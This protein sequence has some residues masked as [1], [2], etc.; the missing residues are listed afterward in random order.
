[1]NP[2][3]PLHQRR[4]GKIQEKKY[5][6]FQII[7]RLEERRKNGRIVSEEGPHKKICRFGSWKPDR[8]LTCVERSDASVKDPGILLLLFIKL[9]VVMK[10]ELMV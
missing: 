5:Q 1:M 2:C 7:C 9:S 3:Q 4:F 6:R 8:P 10:I